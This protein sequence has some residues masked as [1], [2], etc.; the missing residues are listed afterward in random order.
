MRGF[1][2]V[3]VL[4][5]GCAFGQEQEKHVPKV[6]PVPVPKGPTMI[7][8]PAVNPA[9]AEYPAQ[10]VTDA[11]TG[12]TLKLPAGWMKADRDG[13][14]ST[15]HLDA[16]TAAKGAQLRMVASLGFNPFPRSTFSGALFYLSVAKTT[17]VDCGRQTSTAPDVSIAG[18]V[19]DDVKF[20]RGKDEHGRIC[21]QARDIAYTTMRKGV[22]LRFDL[23]VNTFCGG[24]VSG[25]KEITDKELAEV[26]GRMEG[27]LQTVTFE[28]R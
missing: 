27:I 16:R 3:V 18:A 6:V 8:E 5:V 4:L 1:W 11:K 14:M 15:F 24:D 21:T 28:G 17:E 2:L 19:I 12:V 20:R 9:L 23:A 13:E 7:P 22:C 25:V 26:F 10:T